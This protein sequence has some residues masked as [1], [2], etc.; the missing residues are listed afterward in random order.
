MY[1]I[2]CCISLY[3]CVYLVDL[4]DSRPPRKPPITYTRTKQS[5]TEVPYDIPSST[6]WLYLQQNNISD[7]RKDAF[8]F[9]HHVTLLD[10]SNNYLKVLKNFTFF[11]LRRLK[12]IRLGTN[13]IIKI[14]SGCFFQTPSIRAINLNQNRLTS[15]DFKL[16]QL[17][18]FRTFSVEDNLL[19]KNSIRKIESNSLETLILRHNLSFLEKGMFQNIPMCT[20]L[21]LRMCCI[22]DIESQSFKN[23]RRL[24]I[25]HLDFN[26]IKILR[27]G[28]FYHLE[29]LSRIMLNF[30]L[31]QYVELGG[32]DGMKSIKEINLA[33]NNLKMIDPR[34]LDPHHFVFNPHPDRKLTL[35]L[36][37]SSNNKFLW[38]ACTNCWV[39]KVVALRRVIV[40]GRDYMRYT[41]TER[42]HM[43]EE[44][45]F[46]CE[47]FLQ[48][49]NEIF[50]ANKS[51]YN[52]TDCDQEGQ[53]QTA[54]YSYIKVNRSIQYNYSISSLQW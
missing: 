3:F 15:I 39:R 34:I 49:C 14:M 19:S 36:K 21:F 33:S 6:N 42:K 41:T 46:W 1:V 45:T 11:G 51:L 29:S 10:L 40:N 5:L 20:A 23:L 35:K 44:N 27:K 25:L 37:M 54:N 16:Q 9:L 43:C 18:S 32:L 52:N 24:N 12:T 28:M 7:I 47:S 50:H 13:L 4:V 26:Y 2:V 17:S 38:T 31:I 8:K 48:E 22:Q 53:R 30:N